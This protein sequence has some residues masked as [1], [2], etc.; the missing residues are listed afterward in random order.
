MLCYKKLSLNSVSEVG[1][2]K[3]DRKKN[4]ILFQ[5][6]I[7]YSNAKFKLYETDSSHGPWAQTADAI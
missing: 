6:T 3:I 1:I 5:G 4:E 2:Y 7:L